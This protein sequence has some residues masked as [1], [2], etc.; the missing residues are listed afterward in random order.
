M[1]CYW[2]VRDGD[3]ACSGCQ[4]WAPSRGGGVRETT[5]SPKRV[6]EFVKVDPL[7]YATDA[8]VLRMT[9]V[10]DGPP[11]VTRFRM[12]KYGDFPSRVYLNGQNFWYRPEIDAWL[13]KR[14]SSS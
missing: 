12:E 14:S 6:V 2:H 9:G 5:R 7:E 4:H 11:N 8:E 10:S 13:Q 3:G 1:S